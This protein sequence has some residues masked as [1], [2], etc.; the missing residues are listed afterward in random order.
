MK[1]KGNILVTS[2]ENLALGF[3]T[4]SYINQAVQPKKMAR[5]LKFW[6]LKAKGSYCLCSENEGANQLWGCCAADLRLCL[7][8]CKSRFSHDMA[9][10]TI[11]LQTIKFIHLS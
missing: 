5:G 7:C 1:M 4:R 9:H 11:S 6:I 10:I 8:I 3:L 2:Q